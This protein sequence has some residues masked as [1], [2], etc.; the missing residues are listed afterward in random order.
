MLA[1]AESIRNGHCANGFSEYLWE[2]NK[3]KINTTQFKLGCIISLSFNKLQVARSVCSNLFTVHTHSLRL[4]LVVRHSRHTAPIASYAN[5]SFPWFISICEY[6][7]LN[8]S[9]ILVSRI[10][11]IWHF[12]FRVAVDTSSERNSSSTCKSCCARR[13]QINTTQHVSAPV[14]IERELESWDLSSGQI[15]HEVKFRSVLCAN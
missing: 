9:L 10:F 3:L 4:T 8:A 14:C 6:S 12:V 11:R 1:F 15:I 7:E 5:F 13:D 2:A